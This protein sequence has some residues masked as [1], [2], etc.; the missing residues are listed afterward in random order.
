MTISLS[1]VNTYK[2]VYIVCVWHKTSF[3][4]T[5]YSLP[6]YTLQNSF[7]IKI[8]QALNSLTMSKL[9]HNFRQPFAAVSNEFRFIVRVS[10]ISLIIFISFLTLAYLSVSL[11]CISRK[12]YTRKSFKA[13]IKWKR[14]RDATQKLQTW[15]RFIRTRQTGRIW[16]CMKFSA[17]V[18]FLSL[19]LDIFVKEAYSTFTF[20]I[21]V[22]VRKNY[23]I[24]II[25]K[26]LIFL[27]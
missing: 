27:K 19:S 9:I 8:C 3:K 4:I 5:F 11:P 13:R 1:V 2:Y 6:P 16:N 22:I 17:S 21:N 18:I 23:L 15:Q 14:S 24:T 25:N 26:F 12:Q 20:L 10:P 7:Q